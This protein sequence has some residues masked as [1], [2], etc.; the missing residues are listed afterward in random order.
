M[1]AKVEEQNGVAVADALL[2]RASENER[3][4][5]LLGLANTILSLKRSEGRDS[6]IYPTP[7][8]NGVPCFFCPVPTAVA[9]HR[10]VAA[11]HRNDLS[12]AWLQ[13]LF[14]NF[15][16]VSATG[17]SAIAPVGKRVDKYLVNAGCFRRVGECN[18]W[19]VS[20]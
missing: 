11:D 5:E 14:A 9:I 12:A 17:W 16:I 3:W 7:K 13:F 10:E 4:P 18:K 19:L 15:E 2:V 20:P 6:A 8:N 1:G